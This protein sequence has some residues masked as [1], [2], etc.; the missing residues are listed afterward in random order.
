MQVVVGGKKM[1]FFESE[2]TVDVTVTDVVLITA[3]L[4]NPI[5]MSF[6]SISERSLKIWSAVTGNHSDLMSTS[7]HFSASSESHFS[8]A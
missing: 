6:C 4:Y 7:V 1:H 2:K 5:A 8:A 3:A